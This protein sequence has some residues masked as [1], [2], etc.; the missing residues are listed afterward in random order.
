MTFISREFSFQI[1]QVRDFIH[2][3]L[4]AD[5][6]RT[7]FKKVHEK[8]PTAIF[9]DKDGNVLEEVLLEEMKRLHYIFNDIFYSLSIDFRLELFKLL[10]SRGIPRKI[11][12]KIVKEDL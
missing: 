5:Y 12:P 3:S 1:P 10:D 2:G 7:E 8:P 11:L 6:E 4:T 9:Y